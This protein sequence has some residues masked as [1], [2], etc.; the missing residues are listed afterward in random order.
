MPFSLCSKQRT[1]SRQVTFSFPVRPFTP[2]IDGCPLFRTWTLNVENNVAKATIAAEDKR[3]YLH[4]GIDPIAVVRAIAHDVRRGKIVEGGSTITQQAAKLMLHR[5][6]RW[7]KV[8]EA[9]LALK[10][11]ARYSKKEILA[12]YLNLA[13]YGEQ[14]IGI[15]RASQRYFGC[16]PE[17]LT[18]AQAAYLAALPQRP[19]SAR[20][21]IARQRT[22]LKRMH[23]SKADFAEKFGSTLIVTS[24]AGV[25][26]PLGRSG[27]GA[28][29]VESP[30][31]HATE[32]AHARQYL[33]GRGIQL[34]SGFKD[35]APGGKR[36]GLGGQ[37]H[38]RIQ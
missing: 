21:A 23:A 20:S 19:S 28:D 3:F 33:E 36:S 32:L 35:E 31:E 27:G 17:Q 1:K 30:E 7:Q 12:L 10:L 14:T 6:S 22:V 29:P 15:V 18:V 16:D 37:C 2:L 8:E 13:P 9:I 38:Q 25:L 11:E 26:V 4:P 5:K 24:V 34:R